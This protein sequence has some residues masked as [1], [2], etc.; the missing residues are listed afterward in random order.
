MGWCPRAFESRWRPC[1]LVVVMVVVV[2]IFVLGLCV[3][4]SPSA[5]SSVASRNHVESAAGSL[6][7]LVRSSLVEG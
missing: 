6:V 1:L 4:T 3:F 2:V 5:P 7:C